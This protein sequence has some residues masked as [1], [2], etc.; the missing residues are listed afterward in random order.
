MAKISKKEKQRQIDDF[1]AWRDR[2]RKRHRV[3]TMGEY[4]AW[5]SGGDMIS[6]P[7]NS[8]CFL[9]GLTLLVDT[10]AIIGRPNEGEWEPLPSLR[11]GG[12]E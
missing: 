12:G 10:P 1:F 2:Q 4:Q 8:N 11:S 5:K 6:H 3:M 9:G 7:S